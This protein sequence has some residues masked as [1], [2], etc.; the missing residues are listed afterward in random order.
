MP[1]PPLSPLPK[2]GTF[3][4]Q[5][6]E[7]PGS[8]GGPVPSPTSGTFSTGIPS[9]FGGILTSVLGPGSGGGTTNPGANTSTGSNSASGSC[10][11]FF[12][13]F[14]NPL[15]CALRLLFFILGIV[16]VIGAIYLYKPT[17]EIVAAPIRAA[18]EGVKAAAVGAAAA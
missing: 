11:S 14:T 8:S 6:A 1:L 12:S 13:I 15:G 10:S 3:E 18:K 16:C 2:L 17:S 7:G 9:P 5:Y 4:P